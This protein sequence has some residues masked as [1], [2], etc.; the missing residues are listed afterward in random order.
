MHF[1]LAD[2]PTPQRFA[3]AA[4]TRPCDAPGCARREDEEV[5][6]GASF[7]ELDLANLDDEGAGFDSLEWLGGG[8]GAGFASLEW[9]GGGVSFACGGAGAHLF[10]KR[11]P[12]PDAGAKRPIRRQAMLA[13][14]AWANH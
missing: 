4:F 9:L 3:A 12:S 7:A 6:G 11:P 14:Y 1:R 13:V 8:V 5:G 10:P 2:V